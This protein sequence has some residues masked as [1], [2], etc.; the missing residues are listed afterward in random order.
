MGGER[1]TPEDRERG[2]AIR[3]EVYRKD[4]PRYDR[5]MGLGERVFLGAEHRGWVCSQAT[6]ATL[7][8]AIGT[9]LNLPHYPPDVRLT[10]IDLSP[11]M[12]ELAR[13][14]AAELQM[15]VELRLADAQDLPFPDAAFD[16]VVCTYGLCSVPDEVRTIAEMDRVLAPGGSLLLVDHI[17]SSVP[18][19]V[20]LQRLLELHPK[21][22]KGEL[23]RR[24]SMG[25]RAAGLRILRADRSRL[26]MVERLMARKDPAGRSG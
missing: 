18:P 14:R 4:A 24:P 15:T 7:E 11:E 21:R 16:S 20:W 13:R 5:W 6:G 9:G 12:L 22:I 23:T 17:R 1:L 10:G 26:G 25:V 8:V 19:I 2:N 3:R